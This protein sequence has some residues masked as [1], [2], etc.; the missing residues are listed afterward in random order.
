MISPSEFIPVAR[1]GGLEKRNSVSL[2]RVG[3][4]FPLLVG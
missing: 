4:G 2:R 1:R 3:E